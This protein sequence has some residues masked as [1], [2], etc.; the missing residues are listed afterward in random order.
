MKT[1]QTNDSITYIKTPRHCDVPIKI[2]KI[3]E[4]RIRA[5]MKTRRNHRFT[6]AE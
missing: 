1:A 4:A 5:F 3:L 6:S 2:D